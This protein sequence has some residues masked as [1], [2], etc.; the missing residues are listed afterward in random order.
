MIEHLTIDGVA[1]RGDGIATSEGRNVY[2]PYT[3]PGERVEVDSIQGHPDRRHLIRIEQPS[4]ERIAPLCPHFGACGGCA[5][6]HWRDDKYRAWK[7]VIVTDTLRHAGIEIVIDPLIDAHGEGRRRIAVHARRGAHDILTVGFAAPAAHHIIPIDHCPILAPGLNGALP[8]AWAIAEILKP[9]SKP[10]DIHITAADNGLDVDVRGSG[11][12]DSTVATALARAAS[13]HAIARITRHGEIVAQ[14]EEPFVAMG[15]ARVPLPPGSFL[16]ATQEG[17]ETLARLVREYAGKS[18]HIAD[19]FC[20]AGPFALRL[21]MQARI[22]A[23]DSDAAAIAALAKAF[24]QTPRLKPI[25][26][27]ARDLF[28]RPLLPM[29]LNE[30]DAVVF[31]PPRQGAQAQAEQIAKSKVK[32]VIAV[33]CNIATFTRDAALLIAGGY[34]AMRVTPVDQ[35]RHTPHV[36]IVALFMRDSR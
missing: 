31:D 19:L 12:L 32:R 7:H 8:A 3:L 30:F 5:I 6:Q 25:D 24:N 4:D 21:A 9:V 13:S 15:P 26:A 23:R 18:K 2:V 36:E 14:R 17:E 35:F 10:L 16:Q 34:R 27:Q 29:E 33:S 11:P 22:V 1:H 28:R 20:G